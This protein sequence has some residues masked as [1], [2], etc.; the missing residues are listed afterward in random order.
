MVQFSGVM[1]P[2]SEILKKSFGT[3]QTGGYDL[4]KHIKIRRGNNDI[5]I[6]LDKLLKTNPPIDQYFHIITENDIRMPSQ[7][8]NK[9]ELVSKL[10]ANQNPCWRAYAHKLQWHRP[11]SGDVKQE[12]FKKLD[13]LK[14]S[15]ISNVESLDIDGE[16]NSG[17]ST[18]LQWLAFEAAKEGYPTIFAR[19]TFLSINNEILL[20][21]LS[22]L[23]NC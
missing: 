17:L 19:N 9:R 7:D 5:S 16:A 13:K 14:N 1:P 23:N 4:A 11:R 8:E 21:F 10:L 6:P 12:L 3:A 18:I 20:N 22:N 2:L 15:K